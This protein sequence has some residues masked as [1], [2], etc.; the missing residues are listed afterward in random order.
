MD[1]VVDIRAGAHSDYGTSLFLHT[2]FRF[3]ILPKPQA[4]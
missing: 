4:H 2:N 1:N 3:P